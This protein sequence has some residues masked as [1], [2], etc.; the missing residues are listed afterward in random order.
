MLTPMV[1]IGTVVV[2]AR[3]AK[4]C[5]RASLF[6]SMKM[7]SMKEQAEYRKRRKWRQVIRNME[8]KRKFHP[9]AVD[10]QYRAWLQEASN[11]SDLIPG[12]DKNPQLFNL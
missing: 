7:A 1:Y 5:N 4:L 10:R 8:R 2:L 12:D 3:F 6:G 11:K 9:I